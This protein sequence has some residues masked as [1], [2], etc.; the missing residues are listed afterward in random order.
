MGYEF[1][2]VLVFLA[3]ASV[4][5][6]GALLVGRFVRPQIPEK[7]KGTIYECGERPIGSAR[8]NFNPRFYI[9]ALVFII[10]DVEIALTFPVAVVFR[11]WIDDGH[12]WLALV[13][14]LLFIVVLV[15]G[16]AYVWGKGRL[17]WVRELKRPQE[18]E[19]RA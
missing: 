4:F 19:E 16:L 10:F 14:L 7:D 15:L 8:F 12:G 3:I 6:G 9:I 5:V 11:K 17:E 1:A 2:T 13:E 18:P